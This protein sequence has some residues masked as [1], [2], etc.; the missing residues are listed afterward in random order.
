MNDLSKFHLIDRIFFYE[1]KIKQSS[2]I[3]K[4]IKKMIAKQVLFI[5][6][7]KKVEEIKVSDKRNK[8]ATI[9]CWFRFRSG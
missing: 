4:F 9:S 7:Q 6:C 1:V 8:C 3:I 5:A 2:D